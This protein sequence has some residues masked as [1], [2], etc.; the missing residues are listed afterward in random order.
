[1]ELDRQAN[2]PDG[3]RVDTY[4]LRDVSDADKKQ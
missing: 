1:V 2:L 3:L 4:I